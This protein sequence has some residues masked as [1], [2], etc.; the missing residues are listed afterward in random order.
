MFDPNNEENNPEAENEKFEEAE[1]RPEEDDSNYYSF[2]NVKRLALES[3]HSG[4]VNEND[5][6][7]DD[8]LNLND[9]AD[10]Q[11]A[12]IREKIYDYYGLKKVLNSMEFRDSFPHMKYLEET[13][14]MDH[15]W[16]RCGE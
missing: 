8:N 12:A 10:E 15:I 1:D 16:V 13:G 4:A 2:E 6:L 11:V 9:Q 5:S 3:E 14:L 7:H